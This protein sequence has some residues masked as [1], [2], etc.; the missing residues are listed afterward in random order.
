[1]ALVFEEVAYS[2]SRLR[3]GRWSDSYSYIE[4]DVQEWLMSQLREST[5]CRSRGKVFAGPVA[6]SRSNCRGRDQVINAVLTWWCSGC[7]SP[8]IRRLIEP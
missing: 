4:I 5:C 3:K 7:Q 6:L 1:M 2:C 8:Q